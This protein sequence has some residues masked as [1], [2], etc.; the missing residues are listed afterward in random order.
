MQACLF[1]TSFLF[2][3]K[4]FELYKLSLSFINVGSYVRFNRQD[5]RHLHFSVKQHHSF[6][7]WPTWHFSNLYTCFHYL[8]S[9]QCSLH[10]ADIVS[11]AP[12][13]LSSL[14]HVTMWSE[15]SATSAFILSQGQNNLPCSVLSPQQNTSLQSSAA[16]ILNRTALRVCAGSVK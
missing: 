11:A 1:P 9:P 3:S 14:P 2:P 8:F 7:F 13:N 4:V 12:L 15:A 5:N 10:A 6:F 16:C